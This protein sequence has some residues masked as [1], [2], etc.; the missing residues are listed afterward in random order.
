VDPTRSTIVIDPNTYHP[1][2]DTI[3]SLAGD[4]ILVF[5]G[6]AGRLFHDP[7]AGGTVRAFTV[8]RVLDAL[9]GIVP[10]CC[11]TPE[12][13]QGHPG[14]VPVVSGVTYLVFWTIDS[15]TA[16]P[17]SCVVGGTR[18]LFRYDA[19]SETVTRVSMLPSHIPTSLTLAQL[20]SQFPD[21]GQP[22][23]ERVPTPP[24]CSPSV[25]GG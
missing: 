17:T 22:V 25:T 4:S 23:P 9:D 18:G 12:I 11:A 20:V 1:N 14:D 5:I 16:A 19:A 2:Y 15:S 10:Q 13:P 6:T 8:D 24:V 3:P 7:S 21:P